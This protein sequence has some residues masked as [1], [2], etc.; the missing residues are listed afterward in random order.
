MSSVSSFLC[1][2]KIICT[3]SIINKQKVHT[4][5]AD[6]VAD[7]CQPYTLTPAP[8]REAEGFPGPQA[9]LCSSS[10]EGELMSQPRTAGI[11]LT[12]VW[13][14]YKGSP[15]L[16]TCH[17][18]L[19]LLNIMFQSLVCAVNCK[20][21]VF[22]LIFNQYLILLFW[23]WGWAFGCFQFGAIMSK[24]AKNIPQML[25]IGWIGI[26]LSL[27]CKPE[28]KQDTD[29][30]MF[31]FRRF[32]WRVFLSG[33]TKLH[34]LQRARKVALALQDD[35]YLE[36]SLSSWALRCVWAWGT[37]CLKITRNN[38]KSQ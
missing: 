6:N 28:M 36:V 23:G 15:R 30:Y 17:Y 8:H 37:W 19:S 33:H 25:V 31:T 3:F 18:L 29:R 4:S 14:S 16:D 34:S 13:V 24:T 10:S 20:C 32:S 27:W 12:P 2:Y 7:F 9:P 22:L 21:S 26:L 35:Q 5:Y 38:R 11:G 1:A